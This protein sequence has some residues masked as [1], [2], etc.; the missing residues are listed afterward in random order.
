MS[1][2]TLLAS[3]L[4]LLGACSPGASTGDSEQPGAAGQSGDETEED[5]DG[6]QKDV[7]D[8]A[9]SEFEQKTWGGP[10]RDFLPDRETRCADGIDEDADGYIDLA[11][12][13]CWPLAPAPSAT[14]CA[15]SPAAG[16]FHDVT[17]CLGL[18]APHWA[19][20]Y[21]GPEPPEDVDSL[22]RPL[23]AMGAS[24]L[25]YDS[26]GYLDLTTSGGLVIDRW[27][28][29][30]P[31][32]TFEL[33]EPV[34][35][36][37]RSLA[38]SGRTALDLGGDDWVDLY[39]SDAAENHLLVSD[40]SGGFAPPPGP[41]STANPGYGSNSAWADF[42]LDG[43][44]D[45]Y[46]VNYRCTGCSLDHPGR[47]AFLLNQGEGQFIDVISWLPEHTTR[48]F[49][50]VPAWGD[51]DDDGDLDLFVVNDLGTWDEPA[52]QRTPRLVVFRNDG[53]GCEGW[54]FSEVAEE[55]GLDLRIDG[56]GFAMG[57]PDGGEAWWFAFSHTG[58]SS[59]SV[60]HESG[61]WFEAAAA[62]GLSAHRT[63]WGLA[64]VD[65]DNDGDEDLLMA[66]GAKPAGADEGSV[67]WLNDGEGNFTEAT[68]F[69]GLDDP[70]WHISLTL[71]DY[72]R[73]GWVDVLRGSADVGF[74][75][76]RNAGNSRAETSGNN[77]VALRLRPEPD[78]AASAY[79]AAAVGAR[80]TLTDTSGRRHRREVRL[81]EGHG[82]NFDVTQHVGLGAETVL[83][84]EVRWPDGF[85]QELPPLEVNTTYVVPRAA[86]VSATPP[87]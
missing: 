43:D 67:L 57:S 74:R 7:S 71:A 80:I 33:V 24:W 23:W 2:R 41:S 77:W 14:P 82:G 61:V 34:G 31:D 10:P 46:V 55:W 36:S 1:R 16:Y 52:D 22:P 75:L 58:P 3:T 39:I 69:S 44:L 15:P 13:D 64:F 40:G 73:D 11:D 87:Q 65:I 84:A 27:Y 62:H 12:D 28:A 18:S 6:Q 56:M 9:E 59:L 63:G 38:S 37:P 81:G 70:G 25:D 72:D 4:L 76:F 8:S 51:F 48:G 83:H 20:H 45:G 32:G 26:D 42:D 21:W 68:E 66:A 35:G 86:S 78:R 79:G 60:P 30:N 47:D 19:E 29:G 54:C 53:P 17:D 49:G 50:F 5:A 85:V